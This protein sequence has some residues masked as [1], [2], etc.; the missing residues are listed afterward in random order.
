MY[1]ENYN[2][3][4]N[5]NNKIEKINSSSNNN[6]I[7]NLVNNNQSINSFKNE[8]NI[9]YECND[10]IDNINNKKKNISN[11]DYKINISKNNSNY[12][13][14]NLSQKIPIK[15][16]SSLKLDNKNSFSFSQKSDNSIII[17]KSSIGSKIQIYDFYINNP[18]LNKKKFKHISNLISTT[19]Y[20]FITFIPKSLIIQFY[21]LSNVYFLA[22][23]IIQSIPIISPL[24]SLTAI[25][26]LIFVLFVSMLR[27][28]IEDLARMKYD[29]IN[30]KMNVFIF[31]NK[32]FQKFQSSQINVGDIL[33]IKDNNEIPCDIIIFDTNINEGVCYVETSSLDGEKNLKNKSNNNIYGLFCDKNPTKF[34]EILNKNFELNIS[35][36]GQSDFPNNILNKCDGYLKIIINENLVEFPFNINNILLKGSILKNSGWVI[37]MALYTGSNNKIILNSKLP[38]IKLSKIEKKMNKFLIGI[39]IFQMLLC[40]S[41]SILFKFYYHQHKIF[42]DRFITLK[43]S[44]NVESVL[45]FFTYFLLL[46]TYIP[47]SLIVTLEIVKLFLSFFI[48]WDIN[49]FSFVKQKFAKA[50]SISILEEL[51]NVDYIFSDKTGTLTSNKMVFKYAIIDKKIYQYDSDVQNNYYNLNELKEEKILFGNNF[52]GN[53][54]KENLIYLNNHSIQ[55]GSDDNNNSINNSNQ[56]HKNFISM[57]KIINEYWKALSLCNECIANQKKEITNN[58]NTFVNNNYYYTGINPDDVELVRIADLQGFSL[59]KSQNGMKNIKINDE[60]KKHEILNYIHFSSDRKRM[61]IILKDES[62]VIK[63]YT[64]GADCEIL[65]RL[66]KNNNNIE[67]INFI[68]NKIDKYSKKGYRTLLIGYKEISKEDYE[69]WNNDLKNYKKNIQRKKKLIEKNNNKI[70]NELILLGGTI[71]EDKLQEGVP[72]CIKELRM[73]GIKIW[74]LTGDKSDTAENIALSCNLINDNQKIFRIIGLENHEKRFKQSNVFPE[75]NKFRKEFEMF[76][77]EEK[78]KGKI[79]YDIDDFFIEFDNSN[80]ELNSDKK[81]DDKFLSNLN[82]SKNFLDNNNNNSKLLL[83]KN[84]LNKTS[85]QKSDKKLNKKIKNI[86]SFSKKNKLDIFFEESMFNFK[87]NSDLSQFSM[88]I[89]SPILSAIFANKVYTYQFL[90]IAVLANT[91]ICCRVSPLQKSKVINYVKNFSPNSITLAIGDGGNDVSMLLESHIGIGIYGEEGNAAV[92]ASDVS[93]GEFK[94]LKRLLLFHGRVDN[95]R[96]GQL[97]LYFFYKNFVFTTTQYFFGFFCFMSGQTIIDDWLITLYNLLF[98]SLPLVVQALSDFDILEK[99]SK[100]AKKLFPFLYRESREVMPKFNLQNF[101]FYLSRGL[102][103][104]IVAFYIV[105]YVDYHCAFN[106]KGDYGNIW[107]VSIKIYTNILISISI[108]LFLNIRYITIFFPI[109]LFLSFALYIIFLIISHYLIEFKSCATVIDTLR[110]EKFYFDIFIVVCIQFIVD[111]FSESSKF[112][113]PKEISAQLMILNKNKNKNNK[114]IKKYFLRRSRLDKFFSHKLIKDSDLNIKQIKIN[115]NKNKEIKE[116]NNINN[117]NNIDDDNLNDINPNNIGFIESKYNKDNSF[118]FSNKNKIEEKEEKN[119]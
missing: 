66:S 104:G 31:K 86:Q 80:L 101:I 11:K 37:G 99:D 79:D 9:T 43:Y 27:E 28:L 75:I 94:F 1:E 83:N 60:E 32:K 26:P 102:L 114:E 119:N 14:I 49:M 19:K 106:D 10:N 23:A 30:N 54:I 117:N 55:N 20:N 52:F 93:I 90:K 69:K 51:G 98:T 22:T 53:L 39:F 70:E 96:I 103:T 64:K 74:V 8:F 63:I 6:D 25:F 44:I 89:E 29:N 81:F 112:L 85:F 48:N 72:D 33:L 116:N 108:T 18:E 57:I 38:R 13:N 68:K 84:I 7:N 76:M 100:E 15:K 109:I 47:I 118:D 3:N 59:L 71:V 113:F 12:N 67:K 65:K 34:K 95:N 36:H 41:S 111:Y 77:K 5:N 40:S 115:K 24:T 16:Q 91:V 62:N 2:N 56:N 97:I 110:S 50:K 46:N 35:G 78:K 45:V 58:N 61:S 105:V 73:A 88:I 42:Y 87:D 21:R 82:I 92:Q 107:Y 17:S 4:N